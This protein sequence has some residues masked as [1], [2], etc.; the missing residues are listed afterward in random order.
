MATPAW[1]KKMLAVRG[2]RFE[3]RRHRPAFTAQELAEHEHVSGHKV[4][5]VVVVIVDGKPVELILP[6]SRRVVLDRVRTLLGARAVRFASEEEMDAVFGDCEPGAVP[7][8][9]HWPS[10]EVVMDPSMRVEG[11][12]IFQA[13]THEDAVSLRWEDWFRLVNPR[14]GSFSEPAAPAYA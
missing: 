10:I 12:V 14:V 11:E 2:V 1:I 4:V 9:R 6:A 7:P 3:E 5:K 13:G 8:L